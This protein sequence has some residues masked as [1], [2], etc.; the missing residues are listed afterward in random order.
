MHH[1]L[2]SLK[3]YLL[4]NEVDRNYLVPLMTK[5]MSLFIEEEGSGFNLQT[6]PAKRDDQE[7]INSHLDMLKEDKSLTELYTFFTE[8]IKKKQAE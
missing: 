3:D 7:T 4:K 5:T 2:S 1:L 6:G 8:S